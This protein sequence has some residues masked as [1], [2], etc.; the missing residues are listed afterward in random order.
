MIM[1]VLTAVICLVAYIGFVG[2]WISIGGDAEWWQHCLVIPMLI[3]LGVI[4][5]GLVFVVAKAVHVI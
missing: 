3:G 4:F 1:V 5:F 2:G